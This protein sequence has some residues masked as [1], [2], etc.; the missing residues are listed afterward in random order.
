MRIK[1]KIMQI[2]TISILML[3]TLTLVFN[4][5]LGSNIFQA[6]IQVSAPTGSEL[7]GNTP[8]IVK[9][10]DLAVGL[11]GT[12]DPFGSNT[13]NSVLDDVKWEATFVYYDG[14]LIPSQVDDIDSIPFAYTENDELVFQIPKAVTILGESSLTFEVFFASVGVDL[15]IP[16]FNERVCDVYPYPKLDIVNQVHV[17]PYPKLDIVNQVHGWEGQPLMNEAYYIENE[18]IRACALVDCAWSSGGL[19]ELAVLDENKNPTIDL[20]KQEFPFES[21]VWKWTRF[22]LVEQFIQ[23]NPSAGVNPFST[24]RIISG[25][26]RAQIQ[27]QSVGHYGNIPGINAYVTYEL[28]ASLPYL[29]YRLELVG[30]D[31]GNYDSLPL[32]YMNREWGGYAGSIYD[33]LYVPGAG[34]YDRSL[35]TAISSSKFA[36]PW[37]IESESSV[38]TPQRG[39]GMLFDLQELG[40]L[41]YEP[42]SEAVLL[43]YTAAYFPFNTR[44]LPFDINLLNGEVPIDYVDDHYTSVWVH[45]PAISISLQ[46]IANFPYE[47]IGISEPLISSNWIPPGEKLS[48]TGITA[49]S[50]TSG[51]LDGSFSGT[52]IFEIFDDYNNLLLSGDLS[53]DPVSNSWQALDIDL[54]SLPEYSFFFAIATFE[55]TGSSYKSPSST[56]F[57]IGFPIEYAVRIGTNWLVEQQYWDGSWDWGAGGTAF[58]LIKL[59]DRAFELGYDPFDTDSYEYAQNVIDGWQYLLGGIVQDEHGLSIWD[60]VYETGISLMSFAASGMPN[61]VN[62]FGHDFNGDGNADTFGEIAQEIVNWLAYAQI[63]EGPNPN[64][65]GWG[66]EANEAGD[67]SVAG[68]AVLGLSAAEKFGCEIPDFVRDE[69]NIWINKIQD[70]VDHKPP[71]GD[72]GG[73]WYHSYDPWVNLLKTGNLI[74]QM[75]FYGDDPSTQRFQDAMD[76]IERHWHD[77]NLQPGWGY[78][79][80]PAH[81][82]AMYC[83]MKGL[84]FSGLDSIT[85]DGEEWD[86]YQEFAEVLVYQQQPEGYWPNSPCFVGPGG[87]WGAHSGPVLSTVWALLT[88]EKVSPPTVLPLHID[89]KPSSW[90]NSLNTKNEGVIPVAICGS[91]DIDVM[92]I[93]P[94]TISL[95]ITGIAERV[96]PLRWSY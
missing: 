5:G 84:D 60:S 26:V 35:S 70:P 85:L 8:I 18:Y 24:Q 73:S 3:S 20:I 91:D 46:E 11:P 83:L 38:A 34:W 61:R 9:L 27:M 48:I 71:E 59:Q 51:P 89:I 13:P 52:H 30:P 47:Y 69:L 54:S 36:S 31:S 43:D 1:T 15:P 39:Y 90:P 79:N 53:W 25:P 50:T 93:D 64:R 58:V 72:D 87:G 55:K 22:S 42:L 33:Q 66:Y 37:F 94:N 67:N 49:V 45:T 40:D 88:L 75:T 21:K 23:N 74:F 12:I 65:G 76:Y 63:D 28:F 80:S 4:L 86:W 62:I 7:R 96:N 77:A 14:S 82:Q 2:L 17:Y 92:D 29:D 68:Y 10:A 81:Y 44:Y 19:Y 78:E 41:T 32:Y 95:G 16:S 6:D 57:A 56:H